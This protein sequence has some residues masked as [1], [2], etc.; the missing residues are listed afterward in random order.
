MLHVSKFKFFFRRFVQKFH[1]HCPDTLFIC[2]E[3]TFLRIWFTEMR[4]RMEV[5][6]NHAGFEVLTAVVRKSPVFWNITPYRPLKINRRYGG[7]CRL[8]L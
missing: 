2:V 7:T 5:T 8:H 1:H 6:E 4:T 3:V